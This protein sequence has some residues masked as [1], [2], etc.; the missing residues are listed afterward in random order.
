MGI[1]TTYSA[2]VGGLVQF[3]LALNANAAPKLFQE[4][5][6]SRSEKLAGLGLQPFRDWKP[7]SSKSSTPSGP[8]APA[9]PPSLPVAH[10][11]ANAN[12]KP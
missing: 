1:E 6:G 10:P 9:P 7:R 5:Y 11:R 4:C 8:T 2:V 3:V 12:S